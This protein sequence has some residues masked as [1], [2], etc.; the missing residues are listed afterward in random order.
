MEP[1]EDDADADEVNT[2]RVDVEP[3]DSSNCVGILDGGVDSITPLRLWD[4]VMRN[5]KVAQ[6][7]TQEI[8]RLKKA[9]AHD[10]LTLAY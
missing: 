3:V 8:E 7:C 6:L 2:E 9:D 1:N 10:D 5:Y 4:Q